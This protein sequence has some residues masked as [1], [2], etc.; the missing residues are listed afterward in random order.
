MKKNVFKIILII[1]LVVI[2]IAGILGYQ[3]YKENKRYEEIIKDFEKAL[4]WNLDA[5]GVSKKICK[6][7]VTKRGTTSATHL[8]QQGY[9]K[10]ESML[11]VDNKSYCKA[12]ADTFRTKDC[13]IDYKIYL[14]CK[15]YETSGYAGWDQ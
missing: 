13:S 8:I 14:K 7:N 11:D 15:N 9:L 3:K 12:Y 5:T 10:K 2:F 4:I 1:I 6:P